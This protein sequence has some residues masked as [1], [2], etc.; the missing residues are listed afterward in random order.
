MLISQQVMGLRR[1]SLALLAGCAI[2]GCVGPAARQADPFPPR[3]VAAIAADSVPPTGFHN[4]TGFG[5]GRVE[6]THDTNGA[7][8][9]AEVNYSREL[10]PYV[11]L[12]FITGFYRFNE[13]RFSKLD[14]Y[15]LTVAIQ[16][17]N[18]F[19]GDWGRWYVVGGVGVF[20]H[21]FDVDS[22]DLP[23]VN[24]KHPG[25][26]DV[27]VDQAP[28]VFLGFGVEIYQVL[29]RSVNMGIEAKHVWE[30]ADVDYIGATANPSGQ[31]RLD[32]W[33]IR[34]NFTYPF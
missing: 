24:V 33:I 11:S 25:T 1:I 32:T 7:G 9:Y 5:F 4:F 29:F 22:R 10:N 12:D 13:A 6:G 30:E 23:R 14:T 26:T 3:A 20:F 27:D 2:G 21:D 18:E 34:L 8:Y 31:F 15:P 28:G 16:V 17:G 19:E